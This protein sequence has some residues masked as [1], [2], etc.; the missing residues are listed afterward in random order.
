VLVVAGVGIVA[1]ARAGRRP[2][3]EETGE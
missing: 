1:L 2:S 3:T